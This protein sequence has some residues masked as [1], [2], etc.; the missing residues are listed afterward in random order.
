MR[1]LFTLSFK[2][3]R[4]YLYLLL[5][6]FAGSATANPVGDELLEKANQAY[7]A[8]QY[9]QAILLYN[10]A[11]DGQK[12]TNDEPLASYIRH[13]LAFSYLGFGDLPSAIS[14]MELNLSTHRRN[15]D[16]KSVSSYLLYLGQTEF[17][18]GNLTRAIEYLT[19]NVSF[20]S[21]NPGLFEENQAW[22]VRAINRSGKKDRAVELLF[23]AHEMLPATYSRPN[24]EQSA[25]MLDIDLY[26]KNGTDTL[27]V[28]IATGI[29]L[30]VILVV[31][32][33]LKRS[34]SSVINIVL[35]IFSMLI[36]IVVT[37]IF[38]RSQNENKGVRHILHT[39]GKVTEFHAEANVMP[40]NSRNITRFSTNSVGLRG[41]E[42]PDAALRVLAIGGSSTE[43]LFLDDEVAWPYLIQTKMQTYLH[44]SAWVGNA[45]KSG[46]NS[47]SHRVQ[48]Y[49]GLAELRP[50]VLV[51][52]AG[53]NDLNQCISGGM[54]AIRDNMQF[55]Q[56]AD[57]PYHYRNHVF[58]VILPVN[59]HHPFVLQERLGKLFAGSSMHPEPAY[60]YVKQDRAGAFYDNQRIRRMQANK[61][62]STPDI[63]VCLDAFQTNIEYIINL[64]KQS[65]AI[66]I[67]LTQGSLYRR[68][69]TQE[70]SNLLWFGSVNENPFSPV[71]PKYYY[72][73]TVMKKLLDQYN[74]VTLA[75]CEKYR[76]SCLDTDQ[77]LPKTTESYYDDVHLNEQGSQKLANLVFDLIKDNVKVDSR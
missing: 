41:D 32:Y 49:F 64:A 33:K 38:L 37:E 67:L 70:E 39:P 48:V 45:G 5:L 27:W 47:F 20:S 54:S 58:D 9:E 56:W 65:G 4:L 51:L 1:H 36:A 43:A 26:R 15:K 30:I 11:I 31:I 77:S 61:V 71:P 75:L 69:L 8:Q 34:W 73:A 2:N 57:F 68:D 66:P 50:D 29:L 35:L 6:L 12:D 72:T 25:S 74:Q 17:R 42:L 23:D 10:R 40:G 28:L 55:S 21:D 14:L 3:I 46:L 62:M 44:R 19:E 24:L 52:Q 59:Q 63:Q 22:L 53:V 18:L 13:Q 76:L 7:Q 60:A 16:L